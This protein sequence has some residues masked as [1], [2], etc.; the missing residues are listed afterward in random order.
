[1][2][3]TIVPKI[4]DVWYSARYKY[5]IMIVTVSGSEGIYDTVL[6][7]EHSLW[8]GYSPRTST[9]LDESFAYLFNVH[10]LIR[11]CVNEYHN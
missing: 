10:S 9:H 6:V 5:S 2:E 3:N 4:G 7:N 8:A 11:D 1:M